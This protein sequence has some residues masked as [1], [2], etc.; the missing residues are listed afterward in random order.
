VLHSFSEAL[1]PHHSSSPAL[2]LAASAG[3]VS[4]IPLDSA[5][6]DLAHLTSLYEQATDTA[7]GVT[8]LN[9]L[10]QLPKLGQSV[11]TIAD[12]TLKV[13]RDFDVSLTSLSLSLSHAFLV[14]LSCSLSTGFS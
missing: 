6:N 8:L 10:F 4:A 12:E 14:R 9:A 5:K 7:S 11:D 1:D 13:A 2:V 3:M